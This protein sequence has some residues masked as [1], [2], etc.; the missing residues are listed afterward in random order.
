M[1]LRDMDR[2]GGSAGDRSTE[3]TEIKDVLTSAHKVTGHTAYT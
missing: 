3:H 1:L 2:L